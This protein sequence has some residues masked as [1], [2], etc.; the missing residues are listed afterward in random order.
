MI[1]PLDIKPG[2]SYAAEFRVNTW[3]DENGKPVNTQNLLP[4]AKVNGTPGIYKGFGI[5]TK[6]DKTNKLFEIWDTTHQRTWRVSWNDTE[7]IDLIE[8]QE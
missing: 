7:N 5:I 3:I 1:D 6:R 2:T 4:G 8:W